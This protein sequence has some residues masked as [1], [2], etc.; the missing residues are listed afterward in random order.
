MRSK[1]AIISALV[2]ASL[3]GSTLIASAQGQTAPGASNEGTVSPGATPG[4]KTQQEKGM[5][6][7]STRNGANKAGPAIPSEQDNAG[8]G[9]S[10]MAAPKSGS[11]Y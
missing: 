1:P 5:T 3:F 9:A 4:K 11:R 6:T 2:V 8:S 10:N 7:G